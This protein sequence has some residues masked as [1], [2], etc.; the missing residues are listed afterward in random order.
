MTCPVL[1]ATSPTWTPPVKMTDGELCS[2]FLSAL[3]KTKVDGMVVSEM[4]ETSSSCPATVKISGISGTQQVT[5][6]ISAPD[7]SDGYI[8]PFHLAF[9]KTAASCMGAPAMG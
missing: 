2:T 8:L 6:G 5:A 3:L 9:N 7:A 1:A 4:L